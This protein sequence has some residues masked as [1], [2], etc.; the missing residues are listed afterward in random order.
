M[1][2]PKSHEYYGI[3]DKIKND[4]FL[5]SIGTGD[6]LGELVNEE[7]AVTKGGF[8]QWAK[9]ISDVMMY[10]GSQSINYK[11]KRAIDHINRTATLPHENHYLRLSINIDDKKH[12]GM[13]DSSK[14]TKDYLLKEFKKQFTDNGS[15]Q[16]K[17]KVFIEN[18][19]ESLV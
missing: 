5:L 8:R 17:L 1:L 3:N 15:L 2:D 6:Y 10:A 7:R 14:A 13:D 11:A 16:Q 9:P 18:S 4:F 12:K 19:K